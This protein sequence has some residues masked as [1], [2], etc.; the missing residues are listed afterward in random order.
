[1]LISNRL[2]A[3]KDVRYIKSGYRARL[4]ILPYIDKTEY[5][6]AGVLY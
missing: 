1:M 6:A 3:I 2:E 5:C 4:I